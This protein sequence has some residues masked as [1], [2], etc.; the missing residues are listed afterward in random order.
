MFAEINSH[1]KHANVIWTKVMSNVIKNNDN[2]TTGGFVR[3]QNKTQ[4]ASEWWRAFRGPHSSG[5]GPTS[6]TALPAVTNLAICPFPHCRIT[7]HHAHL[8]GKD[9]ISH[10]W[11]PP[12]ISVVELGVRGLPSPGPYFKWFLSFMEQPNVRRAKAGKIKAVI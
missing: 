7:K 9:N 2:K 4:K 11:G 6:I 3:T 1:C 8:T 10:I 5:S 12:L